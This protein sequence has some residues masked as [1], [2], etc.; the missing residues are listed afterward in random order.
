MGM[1]AISAFDKQKA[2]DIQAPFYFARHV[3]EI[4]KHS[5]SFKK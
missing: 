2:S 3:V 1:K 5:I 4:G